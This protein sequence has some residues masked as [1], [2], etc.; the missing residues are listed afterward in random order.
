MK[1]QRIFN[2]IQ[3]G[4]KDDIASRTFDIFIAAVI[5]INI[6]V[7]VLET[8]SGLSGIGD[9]VVTCASMHSRNRRAGIL[10]GQGKSV[11]DIEIL[12][13][14]NPDAPTDLASVMEVP[15][16]KDVYVNGVTVVAA[17]KAST[18]VTDGEAFS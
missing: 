13:Y 7:M 12:Q 3:I 11:K 1:K 2:I 17:S 5:I 9:L 10:I 6:L 16:E 14:A 8:F 15:D 4:N 18:I